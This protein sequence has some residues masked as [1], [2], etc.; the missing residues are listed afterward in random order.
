MGSNTCQTTLIYL[1]L[2]LQLPCCSLC[3]YLGRGC[4]WINLCVGLTSAPSSTLPTRVVFQRVKSKKKQINKTERDGWNQ[5]PRNFLRSI[6]YTIYFVGLAVLSPYQNSDF[7]TILA[8]STLITALIRYHSKN[9]KKQWNENGKEKNK[10]KLVF[11]LLILNLT[12]F[13]EHN[14]RCI[15]STWTKYMYNNKSIN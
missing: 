4:S 8:E 15:Q 2:H 10:L 6:I 9:L 1:Y 13:I 5:E 3:V 12:A 14:P 7:D 11:C